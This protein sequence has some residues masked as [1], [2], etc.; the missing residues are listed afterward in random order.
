MRGENGLNRLRNIE[1][2]GNMSIP[3]IDYDLAMRIK[4]LD[5][6][7]IDYQMADIL[8]K[9]ERLALIDRIK[10]V[11]K[12]INKQLSAEKKL[13]QKGKKF[14]SKFVNTKNNQDAWA[15]AYEH[16]TKELDEIKEKVSSIRKK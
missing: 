11:K 5:V 6:S 7:L 13:L 1:L 3:F 16:Y 15:N 8:S 4:G 2:Y 10:G 12:L 14:I 9:K